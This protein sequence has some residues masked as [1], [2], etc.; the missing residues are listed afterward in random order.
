M[1]NL[2][3]YFLG[4]I[5]FTCLFTVQHSVFPLVVCNCSLKMLFPWL[6]TAVGANIPQI[7]Q[8]LRFWSI[9][10]YYSHVIILEIWHINN[11]FN[12]TS[13]FITIIVYILMVIN[14]LTERY[15]SIPPIC[16]FHF[17]RERNQIWISCKIK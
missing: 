13:L 5:I 9:V 12:Q 17:L 10:H 2:K 7:N 8:F 6:P 15:G 1:Y 11:Y 4:F 16:L 14:D 3:L